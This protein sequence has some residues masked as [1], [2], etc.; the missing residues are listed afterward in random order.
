MSALG[1]I[2]EEMNGKQAAPAMAPFRRALPS[3]A[4]LAMVV[5][6]SAG[7]FFVIRQWERRNLQ[8]E[9]SNLATVRL[10]IL[11]NRMLGS[12]E[13][14]HS[15]AQLYSAQHP[16]SREEFE[17]F[18][19][20]ALLRHPEVQG[21]SWNPRVPGAQRESFE[22]QGRQEGFPDFEIRELDKTGRL[23]RAGQRDEYVPVYFEKPIEKN[24]AALG[25][26]LASNPEREAALA[27]ARDTDK[28]TATAPLR[29]VQETGNQMGFL[30]VLPIYRD[31]HGTEEERRRNLIG[32][33]SAVFRT[34]DLVESAWSN[35]GWQDVE[36][37]IHSGD[38]RKRPIF[39]HSTHGRGTGPGAEAAQEGSGLS[40]L[41]TLDVAGSAWE[42]VF[43]P[44]PKF[45]ASHVLWQSWAALAAGLVIA[46]LLAA[47]LFGWLRRA[48]EIERRV[49]ERTAQLSHEMAERKRVEEELRTAEKKY[50]S[51]FEN[52]IEGVFQTTRDGRYISANPALARLYGY[53][54]PEELMA[55]LDD[56]GLQLYIEPDRRKEFIRAVQNDGAL[57]CFESQVRRKDG[58]IIW[59]SEKARAVRGENGEVLYYEGVV[60]NITERKRA[61]DSLQAAHHALEVR[62]KERTAELGHSNEAL[63]A[64]IIERKKA[65]D[66]AASASKAK[67]T[68]LAHMSHEIRTPLNAVLGH[69]QILQRDKTLPREHRQAIEA[70]AN[71]GAHLFGLIDDV[72]DISK[73]EAGRME[74]QPVSFDLTSLVKRLEAMFRHRC[75]Q[76]RLQ[77]AVTGPSEGNPCWLHGDEGKLRQ[78]LINLLGNAVKFTERGEVRLAVAREP[79]GKYRFEVT[80]TG[81]GIDAEEQARIIIPFAQGS[82]GIRKGGT[83]LGLIIS[84]RQIELMAGELQF[85]SEAGVGSR[86][87]FS[88]PLPQV[89]SLPPSDILADY[90]HARL[91]PGEKVSA[92]VV[93]DIEEN[94]N[95][96]AGL[97]SAAGCDVFTAESGQHALEL[98]RASEP[99]IIFMD[100]WMPG[101]NG[102]ETT[103]A[104]LAESKIK[105]KIVAH[106][107]SAFDHEQ[108]RYLDAGFDDFFAKPFRYERICECLAEHLH[109]RFEQEIAP[110]L[111]PIENIPLPPQLASRLKAA[112][113]LYNVTEMKAHLCE[114]ALLG[115]P[116]EDVANRL[117]EAVQQCDIAFV[118]DYLAEAERPVAV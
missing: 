89:G 86:F 70:I 15:I 14:L 111:D 3:L 16:V 12:M 38:N 50:R 29:L 10:E 36:V 22:A 79:N 93:D 60:E 4:V 66:A 31:G 67:S 59:I 26:D 73:I 110:V 42:I 92:L 21:L 63:Q 104:I 5:S 61:E 55:D 28:A 58:S 53:G 114:L 34:G 64:E 43:R 113:E 84:R 109:V 115:G 91:A 94:R 108:K 1:E 46:L 52:S 71:S 37:W 77:F 11:H 6:L 54:S 88:L 57:S 33:A 20:D 19:S 8:N 9:F 116:A 32:Y 112:A 103:H 81:I 95:V 101:M 96:L 49:V 23:V 48:T 51:I 83:G 27:S 76:K 74:L 24:R 99:D 100:I 56:I 78:I 13:V 47:C 62:V 17:R 44:T 72:L 65:E 30:V 106:S 80:D 75:Q 107:A 90:R 98:A 82:A 35:L 40:I 85:Y 39:F 87:F 105:A 68:F 45:L 25:F 7:W 18:V 97:L 118:L 41:Q 102:I 69:A 117:L 2:S